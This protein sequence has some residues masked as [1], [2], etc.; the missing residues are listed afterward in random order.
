MQNKTQTREALN[1]EVGKIQ[2][3]NGQELFVHLDQPQLSSDGGLLLIASDPWTE[4]VMGELTRCLEEKRR[5]PR[6][7]LQEMIAQRVLQIVAGYE[8]VN[9]ATMLRHDGLLQ[10]S[11]GLKPGANSAL[12]S[13]PTLCRLENRVTKRDLIRLFYAQIDLFMDSYAGEKVPPMLV[14]DLDPTAC[15]TYGQQE[16]GFYNAHVGDHCLMPFHLY[17]G[18]SARLIATVL[19][20]GKTPN[21]SEMISLLKRVQ[22]RIRQRWPR[23]TLMLRA[24][25][26]HTK[27]EVLDWLESQG[28]S[29]TMGY[30]PNAVLER[31]CR[32]QTTQARKIYGQ[33]LDAGEQEPEVRRFHSVTYRSRSWS[34]SR[35]VVARIAITPLGVDLRYIVTS[36]EDAKA[37]GL[38]EKVYCGRG[39]AELYIKEH[40]LDLGGDRLSCNSAKANQFRLFLHGAAY[41][42]LHGFRRTILAGT[43]LAKASFAQLRLKLVKIAS[44]LDADTKSLHLHLPWQH[45]S[46][47]MIGTLMTRIA[48]HREKSAWLWMT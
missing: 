18:I 14:L 20:P 1:H 47:D 39:A 19:R 11:V 32:E 26:H 10:A 38:Y 13:Q 23:V 35:R 5:T 15:L 48:Q 29:Y 25:S 30:A 41:T 8:D 42:I 7:S 17:E 4:R 31:E 40:K 21:A 6:H 45:P 34:K 3:P 36:F 37:K 33:R 22:R 16:L 43:R 46:S 28:I 12:A 44:R 2:G 27:P 24:D 9:D